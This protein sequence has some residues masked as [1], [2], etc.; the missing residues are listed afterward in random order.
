VGNRARL[1][2]KTLRRIHRAGN[3]RAQPAP[4]ALV[5][6]PGFECF[7]A[8]VIDAVGYQAERPRSA[9]LILGLRADG[10]L[11]MPPVMGSTMKSD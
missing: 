10:G 3:E 7:P 5:H 8:K 11:K 4:Q 1:Q 9:N 2:A 6:N